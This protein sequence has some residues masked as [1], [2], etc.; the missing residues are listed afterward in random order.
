[1]N[2]S[3]GG[4]VR[5][6]CVILFRAQ[7]RIVDY[8]GEGDAGGRAVSIVMDALVPTYHRA[9]R[10]GWSLLLDFR[11][12]NFHDGTDLC[13]VCF[14]ASLPGEQCLD[15]VASRWYRSIE[16]EETILTVVNSSIWM[17]WTYL[18]KFGLRSLIRPC[19]AEYNPVFDRV[20]WQEV[21]QIG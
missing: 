21:V 17:I 14:L 19:W 11:C 13:E 20:D 4:G 7:P 10:L 1:M 15:F 16:L 9:H 18:V 3:G 5:V 12:T 6:P 2:V 8:T